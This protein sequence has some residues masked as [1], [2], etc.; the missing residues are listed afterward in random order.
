[1]RHT[2]KWYQNAHDILAGMLIIV[3]L[4]ALII[5]CSLLESI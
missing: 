1:M 5:I 2:N 4:P 3:G